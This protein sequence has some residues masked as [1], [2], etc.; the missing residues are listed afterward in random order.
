MLELNESLEERNEQV[1]QLENA[2]VELQDEIAAVAAENERL[3][4]AQQQST[5]QLT[6]DIH[7]RH[8]EQLA[9]AEQRAA[10]LQAELTDVRERLSAAEEDSFLLGERLEKT[11]QDWERRL[12]YVEDDRDLFKTLYSEAS[13]HAARLATEN[14]ALEARATLAEGQ[15]RDGLAMVRG[16]FEERV[17]TL[18]EEAE[19]WRAQYALLSTRD[20]RTDDDV[21]R[22]AALEPGVREENARL[23]AEAEEV[24]ADM[25]KMA[26]IIAQMT[27]QRTGLDGSGDGDVDADADADV[28]D[29]HGAADE[30]GDVGD[31]VPW[32]GKAYGSVAGGFSGS[33]SR[34]FQPSESV[35][36]PEGR[37]VFVC[38]AVE[39]ARVCSEQFDTPQVC[40]HTS[41][42]PSVADRV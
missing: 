33:P 3:V 12:K 15:V 7:S 4:A 28:A 36:E 32:H 19:R 26:G 1:S 10:G 13:S 20:A 9:A 40:E 2:L 27:A 30:G 24:R 29:A 37:V 34:A 11:T 38:Q 23:R 42:A 17:R 18:Q 31:S 39:D 16:T 8:A 25:E 35:E 21:R 6:D 41:L 22:R 5:E 14:A